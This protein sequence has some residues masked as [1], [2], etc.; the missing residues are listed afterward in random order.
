MHEPLMFDGHVRGYHRTTNNLPYTHRLDFDEDSEGEHDP[1]WLRKH[2]KI[3]IN[4]F[5]DVN[6]GEKEL[7]VMWNWHV[8]KK[9]FVGMSQMPLACEMFIDIHG[10]EIWTRNLYRNFTLHLCNLFDNGMLSS[11]HISNITKRLQNKRKIH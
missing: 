8:M 9:N 11:T 1:G 10:E 6:E 4:E 7:M 5:S 3:L 2:T